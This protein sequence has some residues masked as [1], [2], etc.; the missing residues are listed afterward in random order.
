VSRILKTGQHT[1]TN[2]LVV[3]KSSWQFVSAH[4]LISVNRIHLSCSTPF[5]YKYDDSLRHTNCVRGEDKD[6]ENYLSIKLDEFGRMTNDVVQSE[7]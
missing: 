5:T 6:K 4:V 1:L 3:P 7:V 2:V